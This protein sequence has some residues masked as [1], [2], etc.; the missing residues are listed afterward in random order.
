MREKS[1]GSGES[2]GRSSIVKKMLCSNVSTAS[3]ANQA[4]E[5]KISTKSSKV[6]YD[7]KKEGKCIKLCY[8][9]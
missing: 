7:V 6:P 4:E 2:A 8:F 5:E 1:G 3:I 9:S